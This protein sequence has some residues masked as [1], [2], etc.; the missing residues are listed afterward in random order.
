MPVLDYATE[1]YTPEDR[2]Q[3]EWDRRLGS[4]I[5]SARNWRFFAFGCLAVVAVQGVALAYVS[6][7]KDIRVFTREIDP[8]G[9]VAGIV[10]ADGGYQPKQ[11]E[12]AA[13]IVD[14]IKSIRSKSTDPV[15]VEQAWKRAYAHATERGAGELTA[16]ARLDPPNVGIGTDIH[17]IEVTS[18]VPQS[19]STYQAR[20]TDRKVLGGGK[21]LDT[22]W[23]GIFTVVHIEPQSE[24]ALLANWE[25]LYVDHFDFS[26]DH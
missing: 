17:Q 15:M 7:Q 3:Q 22:V 10:R 19:D 4:A 11:V 12:Y 18:V 2:G 5:V 21:T 26:K 6:S 16:R 25:G 24:D 14:F 20:W 8:H 9:H 13:T 23:T 1:V